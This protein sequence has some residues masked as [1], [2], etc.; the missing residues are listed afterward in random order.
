[1]IVA[2]HQLCLLPWAGFWHKVRECDVLV[3]NVGWNYSSGDVINRVK[4]GTSNLTIPI[5]KPGLGTPIRDIVSE[6]PRGL[7]KISR[8]LRQAVNKKHEDASLF[9]DLADLFEQDKDV[10]FPADTLLHAFHI[11][12][13]H[14][15]INCKVIIDH[16]PSATQDKG[17]SLLAML[18]ARVPDMTEYLTGRGAL[19]YLDKKCIPGDLSVRVQTVDHSAPKTSI[20]DVMRERDPHHVMNQYFGWETYA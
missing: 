9:Q 1:M 4:F 7:I 14:L 10:T 15:D 18:D 8:T 5:K 17:R 19:N 20:V 11:V 13:E 3:L 16:S 12:R 6:G 2:C